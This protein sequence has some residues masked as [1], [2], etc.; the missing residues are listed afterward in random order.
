MKTWAFL[1]APAAVL[2]LA[3]LA[4]S[5]DLERIERKIAQEPAYQTKAPRYCL[6]VFGT[7]ILIGSS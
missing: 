2:L 4:K 1:L 7:G 3:P 6:L 5:V